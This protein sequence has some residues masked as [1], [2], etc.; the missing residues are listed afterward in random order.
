MH[1]PRQRSC[2]HQEKIRRAGPIWRIFIVITIPKQ[3]ECARHTRRLVPPTRLAHARSFGFVATCAALSCPHAEEPRSARKV[4]NAL[5]APPQDEAP[6]AHADLAA[7]RPFPH[8]HLTMSN[9]QS[10]SFP[11]AGALYERGCE[12]IASTRVVVN[13]QIRRVAIVATKKSCGSRPWFEFRPRKLRYSRA[14][15]AQSATRRLPARPD[16]EHHAAGNAERR[17][18]RKM[19]RNGKMARRWA[20]RRHGQRSRLELR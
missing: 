7:R 12:L 1:S 5:Q 4:T 15:F 13:T 18:N 2:K 10:S 11:R 9:S 14:T 17:R 8:S 19:A 16:R 20:A 6:C 3:L